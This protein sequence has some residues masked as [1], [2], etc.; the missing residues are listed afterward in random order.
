MLTNPNPNPNPNPK[1]KLKR[2]QRRRPPKP[3]LS[4]RPAQTRV[5][6]RVER[7]ISDVAPIGLVTKAG[8]CRL[9]CSLGLIKP[10]T[11]INS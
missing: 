5:K 2:R 10:A 9:F 7:K 3:N 6:Q 8:Q 11:G 4:Q 1:P